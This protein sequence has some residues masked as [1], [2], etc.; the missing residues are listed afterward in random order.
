MTTTSRPMPRAGGAQARVI[1]QLL[2]GLG[3][4]MFQ[5]G[6]GRAIAQR[7]GASLLLDT[8]VIRHAPQA[9]PRGYGLD[10]F[11]LQPTFATRADV[12]RYH[13]HGAGLA[14]KIAHHLRGG[15]ATSEILHQYKFGYQPEI[16]DLKPPLYVTGYWQSY[17]Y[18]SGIEEMLRRDFEF[19][20]ALPASAID[21]AQAIS[22]VGA[23]CLHV[24]RGDYTDARYANF[25]GP[26]DIDYYR[27]A[28]ARVRQIVD[29]PEFFI[30]SDDMAWCR[31]NFDWLGGAARFMEYA[32]AAG[33]KA[34]A[35]D[36]QLMTRAEYFIIAN[37]TFSWWAAWLAGERAKLVIAPR[38]WFKLPELTIDDLIPDHWERL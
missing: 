17:R 4:Q 15:S 12:S 26:S 9:T 7:T 10:I 18:L 20:D 2:G 34:H 25:I 22:R 11:K 3:N 5:Y 8:N 19:R 35:S 32:T 16:L 30:F 13:S 21:H 14:G 38:E 1:V 29:R 23:V 24:R 33:V 36:L 31:A 28:V 27:R 6:L 37:S